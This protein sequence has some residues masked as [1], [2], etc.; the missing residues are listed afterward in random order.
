[1][2]AHTRSSS[3]DT[4]RARPA[5][6]LSR[7]R[8]RAGAGFLG[9][10]AVLLWSTT[11][12]AQLD[13]LLFVK[14]VPP[15]VIIVMDTSLQMLEDGNGNFHDPGTY[16]TTADPAVMGAFSNINP[17]TT[18][19]YK[20]VFRGMSYETTP[21]KY[22]ASTIVASPA[23]GLVSADASFMD[24]TRWAIMRQGIVAA[25]TEN[26]GSAFRWGLIRL[27]QRT[28]AWRTSPSCDKPA[29][30]TD[31]LMSLYSDSVP[32]NAGGIGK[33]AV[34]APSVA[35]ASYAQT[36]AP[37]GTVMV[38]PAGN[39]GTT[40]VTIANRGVGDN[41]GIIPAGLGDV[42]YSDRPIDLAL[43]D[44]K[45]AAI[46][47]MGADSA[48]NRACRNTVVILITGGKDDGNATY[49]AAHDPASTAAQ[50]LTVTGGGVTRRVPIHVIGVRPAA[51]DEP[52]MQGIATASGGRYTKATNAAA[53]AA[54]I[55]YAVQS[56]FARS[57]DFDLSQATEYLP[58]SPIVGTVNLENG[59]DSNGS[60]LP[61]TDI[62][63]SSG[64]GSVAL[65]QRSNVLITAGFSMPGFDGRIR[66]YRA[67]KPIADSTKPTGWK[68]VNDGTALWPDLDGRP[69]LKGM[70]RTPADPNSRNIYTY[71]PNGSGGGSMVAFTTANVAQLSPH[72]GVG[73]NTSTLISL[74]RAQP[75]GAV[76][77]STPALMDPPSLD[78]PPDTDYGRSDG[79]GT[80]AGDHKDR[81][82][83][84]FVGAN[85]GMIHAIDARTGYEVWAF[86]PY[87]L[88]PK[89]R[90]LSDG[91]PV[92][93]FD[94]FVDS[95]PKLA[96]V[97]I[98]DE[99]RSLMMFGQGQGGTF[100][101]AFDVTEAG[102]GV[103]PDQDGMS[104]VTSLLSKFDTPDESIV[105]KWAFPNYSHF[106]PTY[107][108][109]FTVTDGTPG[110]RV[111]IFGDL[112][113]TAT[114]AEKTVGY[115][116]SDPAVGPLNL[117][118]S[119]NAVIVGSGYFPDVEAS[120]PNRGAS[121]PKAGNVMYLINADTGEL[122][123]NSSGSA[124]SGTGCISVGEIASNGRKNALQAD[125]TA[126]G[127]NGSFIVNKAFM[128]DIDGRYWRFNFAD[129]GVT[130]KT[131]MVDTTQPIYSSS[132]LLFVGSTDVYMFFSTGSDLL[133][134][135]APGG[136]GTFKLYG[137]KNGLGSATTM[138]T[139]SLTPVTNSSGVAS[140]ERPSTAPSVAG[141]IVFFTTTNESA[142]TPCN[143]FTANL[144]A[145][146][147]TGSA[148]Y[149]SNGNGKLDNNESPIA[150]T[151]A[152]RATAPFI[153]DQHLYL[154]TS[155]TGGA[156]VEKFGDPEDFNNGVGQVGVRILS[157][158]E[159]R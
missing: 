131:Q 80:F 42:G 79:T 5:R 4:R 62:V 98:N 126:A 7:L 86:I 102:M 28:P 69:A 16:S 65:P 135:T 155:G 10:V 72:M 109:T 84:I 156:A 94:Y 92:E 45:A 36:T 33:F 47:A 114:Y 66:A 11:A 68:F 134:V 32:C 18:A 159:I 119:I 153:V 127:D 37:T 125:P 75:L 44:A 97:K 138:F 38:T 59:R 151:M 91:Q 124:C 77:G 24:P 146:T 58:V 103:A 23:T 25:V 82:A 27:R 41:A 148:A 105:F 50:F 149:D 55:N 3:H 85:D 6:L 128:G 57:A 40:V 95:S 132:A 81:R 147:Y 89:L 52:E 143:D 133:P 88:L 31:L 150:K 120:I 53:V 54:A 46:A 121:A 118:R 76:I 48:A 137:L 87:N 111:K 145:V 158:R 19:W 60:S 110:G 34:Y 30:V 8:R 116:W 108:A 13:P 130:T 113:A 99:W 106:D 140:G 90:A 117:D 56:G 29:R 49:N 2:A 39:T 67:Y 12:S 93:Q 51:T 136:T 17:S 96:E 74:V 43:V 83:L 144:Y 78:P 20:R 129:T 112:S 142:S 157:W 64:A 61:N 101:Q 15:T 21:G 154:S 152:G 141:D 100:Y 63:S 9:L 70:A 14:R 115:S 35:Q 73:I 123:G 1:M 104:A 107:T 71:I 26:S 122:I 139:R 22:V